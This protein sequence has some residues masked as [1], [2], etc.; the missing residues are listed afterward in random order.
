[1]TIAYFDFYEEAY[2][3]CKP[4][5]D[6]DTER[7]QFILDNIPDKGAK[8]L[9]IGC[10]A[11]YLT[12]MYKKSGNDVHAI[13]LSESSVKKARELGIKAIHG[14]FMNKSIGEGSFDIVVAGETIEHV[15]DTDAFLD[16]IRMLL[17]PGGKLILTTPNVASLGRRLML[18]IGLNPIL[19]YTARSSDA[20]HI[21]FYTFANIENQLKEHKYKIIK[22]VSSV[23]NFIGSGKVKSRM[24]ANI[25][26]TIGASILIVAEV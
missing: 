3:N 26:K 16:K 1:M 17:K 6:N 19:E 23:V 2:G 20:G 13:D 4:S 10:H 24:L 7:I 11:G 5:Y 25:F 21:R 22:S 18:L 9:D 14:D 8:I 15:F 12:S